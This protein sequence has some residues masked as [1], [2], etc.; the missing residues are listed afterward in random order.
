MI[1]VIRYPGKEP[2]IAYTDFQSVYLSDL[3]GKPQ[4]Q[5]YRTAHKHE[6]G[7]IWLQ[8]LPRRLAFEAT[9]AEP[10]HADT[11]NIA[12]DCEIAWH[13]YDA[14]DEAEIAAPRSRLRGGITRVHAQPAIDAGCEPYAEHIYVWLVQQQQGQQ[15]GQQQQQQQQGQ[16]VSHDGT[17]NDT[18]AVR[19]GAAEGYQ[20]D[21]A[22]AVAHAIGQAQEHDAGAYGET[23]RGYR[24]RPSLAG[25]IDAA[26]GRPA[27][28]RVASYRRPARRPA[29]DPAMLRRGV[30]TVTAA[31][32]LSVYLDRSGSFTAAKTAGANAALARILQRYRGKV[33]RDTYYFSDSVLPTDTNQH[34]GTNYLAVLSHIAATRPQVAVIVTDDDPVQPECGTV[35]MQGTRVIVVPVGAARTNLAPTIGAKEHSI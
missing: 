33:A 27:L 13:L 24:P 25:D 8:H 30:A 3:L 4:T 28:A 1:K 29:H 7:H 32:R 22:Q 9:L 11:W 19:T 5:A 18:H 21:P 15:Q 34:G 17:A 35:I 16:P 23:L 26:L 31:P 20:I 14:D 6:C 12:A 2:A 10:L